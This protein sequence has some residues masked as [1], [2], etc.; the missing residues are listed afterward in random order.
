[1]DPGHVPVWHT[2]V[3]VE[4]PGAVERSRELFDRGVVSDPFSAPVLRAWA[5][6]AVEL[7]NIDE[8]SDCCATNRKSRPG[9]C[10]RLHM[11]RSLLERRSSYDVS[12]VM[13]WLDQRA[14]QDHGVLESVARRHSKDAAFL[15]D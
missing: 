13:K 3:S 10:E 2:W 6:I 11:L 12:S 1:M 8:S 5:S 4:R 7:G 9:V 15:G 14:A